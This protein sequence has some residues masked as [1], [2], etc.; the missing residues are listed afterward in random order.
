[1]FRS[2]PDIVSAAR[3][4]LGPEVGVRAARPSRVKR[5]ALERAVRCNWDGTV[6]FMVVE[7]RVPNVYRQHAL[8]DAAAEPFMNIPGRLVVA[9]YAE[10]PDWWVTLRRQD[11][12]LFRAQP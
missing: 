9:E 11:G 10:S 1:M 7:K 3:Q 5:L 2:Y 8:L 12:A 4:K 6:R